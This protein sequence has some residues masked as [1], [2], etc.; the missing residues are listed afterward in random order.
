MGLGLLG[1]SLI[2]FGLVI[3]GF[4]ILL[5]LSDRIPYIG[6]LPGD[7]FYQK[8]SLKIYFPLMSSIL[9]SVILTMVINFVIRR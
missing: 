8:G 2:V 7:I 9:I 5:T 3:V 4:G 6:R 1:K